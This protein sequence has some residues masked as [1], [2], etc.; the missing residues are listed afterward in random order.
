MSLGFLW[1]IRLFEG[2]PSCFSNQ[3]VAKDGNPLATL[4]FH[5]KSC[6][7]YVA[8]DGKPSE[9]CIFHRKPC[10]QYVAKNGNPS[11]TIIFHRKPCNQYVAK[12]GN[13]SETLIFHRNPAITGLGNIILVH[14]GDS[15]VSYETIRVSAHLSLGLPSSLS[16]N[17]GFLN[18]ST[19]FAPPY[20]KKQRFP[21]NFNHAST[22]WPA[23]GCF[24]AVPYKFR[25]L[26]IMSALT[27]ATR[28]AVLCPRF[29]PKM[30]WGVSFQGPPRH[31]ERKRY[32]NVKKKLVGS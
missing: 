6:N 27:G 1:K 32:V 30:S 8:Q 2:F 12:D 19:V 15:R 25:V 3:Y 31:Q 24:A 26:Y 14:S 7:Q 9:T 4:I 18:L 11:E 21:K 28:S 20:Q 23:N 13:P 10:N 5:R 16:K 22:G 17:K 29:G